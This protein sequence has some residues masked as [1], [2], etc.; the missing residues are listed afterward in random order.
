PVPPVPVPP[1]V[2][3]PHGR[4]SPGGPSVRF[5]IILL[6]VVGTP[7][8]AALVI[9]QQSPTSRPAAN[10]I[11]EVINGLP[12]VL[13]A[14]A[15]LGVLLVSANTLVQ[16]RLHARRLQRSQA[17]APASSS[18][19]LSVEQTLLVVAL[20]TV[21]GLLSVGLLALTI[22]AVQYGLTRGMSFGDAAAV[23]G[24]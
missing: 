10:S 14:L 18:V 24:F 12:I 17:G 16:R 21:A 3:P 8:S 11:I 20:W 2:P 9:A 19:P 4:P 1:S 6:I 7:L 22:Y 13:A 15:I 23:L 5:W